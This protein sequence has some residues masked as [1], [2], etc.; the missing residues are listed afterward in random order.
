MHHS[1]TYAN[2]SDDPSLSVKLQWWT[3][4]INVWAIRQID[5][6]SHTPVEELT[7]SGK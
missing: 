2:V 3:L 5:S 1:V 4:C 7:T 6:D